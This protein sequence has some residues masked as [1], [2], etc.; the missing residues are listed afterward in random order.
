MRIAIDGNIAAGK[1]SVFEELEK[2]FTNIPVEREPV[3]MWTDLLDLFYK[4]PQTWSLA[5]NLKIL[6][7]FHDV[8]CRNIEED[9]MIIERSPLSTRHIFAQ[10][11]Y[12]DGTIDKHQWDLFKEYYDILGWSP[13]AMVFIDTPAAKCLE[14]VE[15]R[16]RRCE[17]CPG[18]GAGSAGGYL[19][20]EYLKRIE[21]QYSNLLKN[22]PGGMPIVVVDGTQS[23]EKVAVDVVAAVHSL[24]VSK[25]N[26]V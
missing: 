12:N 13:D 19:D 15:K 8:F 2:V 26:V 20:L 1:T 25:K 6:K 4:D 7:T 17:V 5:L 16:G 21:F 11:Q 23:P 24:L 18:G 14:R 10:L 22:V 3:G 9:D